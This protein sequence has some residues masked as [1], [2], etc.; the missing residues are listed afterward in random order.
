MHRGV[1]QNSR[2]RPDVQDGSAP[3][4]HGALNGP[5][6]GEVP[7]GVVEHDEVPALHQPVGHAVKV[8]PGISKVGVQLHGFVE[9]AGC[10]VSEAHPEGKNDKQMG[11]VSA[12]VNI[13]GALKRSHVS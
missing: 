12:A 7:L 3:W 13:W 10:F 11:S 1:P 8:L 4:A 6:V 2:S 5:E 9:I